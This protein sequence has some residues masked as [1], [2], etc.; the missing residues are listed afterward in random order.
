MLNVKPLLSAILAI[1]LVQACTKVSSSGDTC[2]VLFD[3]S[4]DW[5]QEAGLEYDTYIKEKLP[6]TEQLIQ[7]YK[8]TRDSIRECY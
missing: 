4:R 2:G 1:V 8:M 5:Q 7:D 3:Y 6:Y